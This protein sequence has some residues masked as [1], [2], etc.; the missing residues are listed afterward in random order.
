MEE[1]FEIRSIVDLKKESL[2][3]SSFEKI[4]E[5]LEKLEDSFDLFPKIEILS[6]F[7]PKVSNDVPSLPVDFVDLM[8]S[9]TTYQI[10]RTSEY[11]KSQVE[12]YI[13]LFLRQ[14]E[15]EK[16]QNQKLKL[17]IS[18]YSFIFQNISYFLEKRELFQ[19]LFLSIEE[20][21]VI[22]ES[23]AH[24]DILSFWSDIS[25]TFHALYFS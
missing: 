25:K 22:C 17:Y 19:F 23:Q 11:D 2:P 15:T 18:M 24:W 7:F 14:I 16:K 10:K 20:I 13:S 1:I 12:L 21:K 8:Y 4:Q 3:A 9:G 5:L 6:L